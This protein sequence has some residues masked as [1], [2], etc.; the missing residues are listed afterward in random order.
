V[1]VAW[2]WAIWVVAAV[3]L[4]IIEVTT[5]SLVFAMFAGGA[6][7][8][9]G[10]AALGFGIPF[11]V[12]AFCVISVALLGVVRPIARRHMLT[13]STPRMGVSALV[14]AKAVVLERV[15]AHD[16]RVK[17]AGEVWTA[18]SYDEDQVL[19]P[20]QSVDVME[21]RGAT[22]LVYGSEAPWNRSLS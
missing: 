14:G 16:G 6:L 13:D 19:E 1:D 15:D 18:R 21:I 2:T 20:G 22:A 12:L 5:L 10:V 4:G 8:A 3:V 17:L 11:Q 9:A 7:A